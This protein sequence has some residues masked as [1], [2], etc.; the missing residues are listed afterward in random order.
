MCTTIGHSLVGYAIFLRSFSYERWKGWQ[1]L[2]L[3]LI[4]ANIPDIDLLFGYVA[5]NPNLYHHF[6][7]HSLVFVLGI[8]G[9]LGLLYRVI[10]RRRCFKVG[11]LMICIMLSHIIMDF[12][13][14]DTSSPYGIQL[15]WPVSQ[16]FYI[17]P[18]TIFRDVSK[19]SSSNAFLESLFCWHNFWTV[20]LEVVLFGPMLIWAVFRKRT[21]E[22]GR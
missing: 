18:V 21:P 4:M 6:W 11:F 15:L 9:L 1:V 2:L 17:S 10:T 3:V 7:T 14:K 12:F 19:A 20:L 13:T 5:G 16:K 8:G 22:N